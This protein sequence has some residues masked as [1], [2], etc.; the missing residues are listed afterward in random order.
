MPTISAFDPPANVGDFSP[1]QRQ[2]WHEAISNFFDGNIRR[3]GG[4]TGPNRSQFYNPSKESTDEPSIPEEAGTITWQGFPKRI[5]RDLGAGTEAAWKKAE[6]LQN[7]RGVNS[8]NQDE[9]LEWRTE[10]NAANAVVRVTFTCEPPEYWEAMAEG[11]PLSYRGPKTHPNA[12]DHGKVLALYRQ[13]AG[14][15]VQEADL[16]P[17]GV[18]DPNNRWNT[19]DG[20]V[21]LTQPQNTLGAEINLAAEATVLRKD[22]NGA[23]IVAEVPLIR[24]SGFGDENRASDPHI[25]QVV[26]GLAARG[27]SLT[28]LNP[29]GLYI[30]QINTQ[31]WTKPG[32]GNTR[33][34]TGDEFWTII[35]GTPSRILRAVYEVPVGV[36]RPDG[37]Q[38]TVSD[39]QIGGIPIRFGGQI[40]K[41]IS[42]K[43][44]A[45]GCREGQSQKRRFGCGENAGAHA[46]GAVAEPAEALPSR[47][48]NRAR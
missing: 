37:Q 10:R 31:G 47:K 1:L 39:I 11:Y 30:H 4:T 22:E 36:M 8:R 12:G 38:M 42:M 43:L 46:V 27:F 19:T 15:Q 17:G 44:V 6:E 32:P 28:L 24:C 25:G 33:V 35:R 9:Y 40:A 20:I 48:S 13:L 3:T 29:P 16:F 45:T 18:Y 7:D 26:N 23:P 21:H 41:R 34:P 5:E 2:A 14:P